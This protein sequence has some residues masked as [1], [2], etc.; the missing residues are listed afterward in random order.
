MFGLMDEF[1]SHLGGGEKGRI[2][3]LID[4]KKRPVPALHF[5]VQTSLIT[6]ISKS[7]IN[8]SNVSSDQSQTAAGDDLWRS[9]ARRSAQ[10]RERALK[11]ESLRCLRPLNF[12]GITGASF[13]DA[14]PQKPGCALANVANVANAHP[15]IKK[16]AV[17][18]GTGRGKVLLVLSAEKQR[19]IKIGAIPSALITKARA[20]AAAGCS[21]R[22]AFWVEH[23]IFISAHS[24]FC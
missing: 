12:T 7:V 18:V 15:P 24:R 3:E 14:G 23:Q 19:S 4:A 13:T 21:C 20:R 8:L 17:R 22:L 5:H 9:D 1:F 2:P 16:L 11:T 6:R 10:K